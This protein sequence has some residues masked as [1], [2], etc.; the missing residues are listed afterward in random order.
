ML[1]CL[2]TFWSVGA[3]IGPFII[4]LFICH[5][6]HFNEHFPSN[7]TTCASN[8]STLENHEKEFSAPC[9]K[10]AQSAFLVMG[11]IIFTTSIPFCVIYLVELFQALETKSKIEKTKFPNQLIHT[12]EVLNNSNK[13]NVL[14]GENNSKIKRSS[15]LIVSFFLFLFTSLTISIECITM[16]YVVN[17]AAKYLQWSV[18]TSSYLI[19]IFFAAHALS[20]A[21][22][23]VILLFCKP[24]V[25]LSINV[26]VCI[27]AFSSVVALIDIWPN[28]V[29]I[30]ISIVGFVIASTY[31][32]EILYVS[33]NVHFTQ[34]LSAISAVG[35]SMGGIISPFLLTS[36]ISHFGLI[37]FAYYQ[38][39]TAVLLFLTLI[40]QIVF[41]HHFFKP[42]PTNYV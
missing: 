22:N 34:T 17:F 42:L 11:S 36:L 3:L 27:A 1:N 26:V 4:R 28:V 7:V 19:T 13:K 2:Y 15:N 35:T 29:Y 5:K 24:V 41:F 14:V 37:F 39:I 38:I 32:S 31:P 33:E 30:A 6:E 9:L 10:L 23:I 18:R 21:S 20:R 16:Q 12:E 8:N 40:M 25:L